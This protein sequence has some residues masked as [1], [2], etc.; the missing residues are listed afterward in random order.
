MAW[1]F[2]QGVSGSNST[3]ASP[4]ATWPGAKTA[5]HLLVCTAMVGT[6]GGTA[7]PG[8]SISD[9][10]GEGWHAIANFTTSGS[11][12]SVCM[13]WTISVGTAANTVTM[14]FTGGTAGSITNAMCLMEYSGIAT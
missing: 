5:G 13:F 4:S 2:V 12:A 7:Y 14:N 10:S 8:G 3:S 1:A 11:K 6:P 9:G